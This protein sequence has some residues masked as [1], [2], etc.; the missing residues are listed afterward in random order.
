[1]SEFGVYVQGFTYGYAA[2]W[3]GDEGVTL[4][5]FPECKCR[6]RRRCLDRRK[7]QL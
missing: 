5:F 4:S 1:M 3:D 7:F 2:G 6:A